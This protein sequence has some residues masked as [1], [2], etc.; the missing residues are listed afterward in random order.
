MNSMIRVARYHLVQPF[1][2]ALLPWVN[3]AFV[4]VVC[5]VIFRMI[6][7]GHHAAVTANGIASV[8]DTSG[9]W[10]GAVA[11]LLV[12]FFVVSLQSVGRS[13]PFALTLGMSRRAYYAGTALLGTALSFA[14]AAGLTALQAIERATGGWGAHMHFFQVPYILDGPWYV[15]WLTAFVALTLAF[16]Y[17]MWN[18]IVYRR[19]GLYGTVSFIAA[20][21]LVALAAAAAITWSHAWAGVGGFLTGLTALGFTGV[22][23]VLAVALLA[24]GHVTIRR[25]TV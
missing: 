9:R 11:A 4:F 12:S 17:G 15:T 24:G 18:G 1:T 20:Q 2:I 16:V 7:L 10:T 14:G 25:A 8:P 23:A 13:M 5:L 22:L 19:W 3:L 21:V 6:P